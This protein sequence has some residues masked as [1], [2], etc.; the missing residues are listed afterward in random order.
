MKLGQCVATNPFLL[1][2][3]PTTE[4][5]TTVTIPPTL[6]SICDKTGW[7]SWMSARLPSSEGESETIDSLR[8][9][10]YFC[11]NDMIENIECRTVMGWKYAKGEDENIVC[12]KKLGLVCKGSKC[13]DYE[14]RVF[15]NCG[16]ESKCLIINLFFNFI[17]MQLISR[18][19]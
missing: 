14:V 17:K 8:H 3:I 13:D 5:P 12:N 16:I 9:N 10:H 2:P 4:A 11:A 19:L 7:T 15:C 18:L 6:P 1:G